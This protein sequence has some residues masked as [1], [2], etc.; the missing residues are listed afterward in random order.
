MY[1][2]TDRER[3]QELARELVNGFPTER[4]FRI[5][6]KKMYK[7]EFGGRPAPT[8]F[9]LME[10]A[11]IRDDGEP[12]DCQPYWKEY[13][14][15]D[16]HWSDGTEMTD[17]EIR[18]YIDEYISVRVYSPYDCTGESFTRFI[19]WHK[20]PSGLVSYINYMTIDV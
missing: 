7:H 3:L 2:Q 13:G 11:R 18:E 15:F 19:H 17:E 9:S 5:F 1:R 16:G 20:N 14:Y 12:D 6:M 4:N 8:V 10:R